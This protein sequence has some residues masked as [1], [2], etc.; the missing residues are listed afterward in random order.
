MSDNQ[1]AVVTD[2]KT[3]S[4][5]VVPSASA[6]DTQDADLME[7]P[8]V[9]IVLDVQ[10]KD[11]DVEKAG[12]VN[13]EAADDT[14]DADTDSSKAPSVINPFLDQI[15]DHSLE[16]G[17]NFF[18]RWI[19]TYLSPLLKLG[20]Q[21]VL[22]QQDV[23]APS[24]EDRA[25]RIY[26]LIQG[27]WASECSKAHKQMQELKIKK[28]EAAKQKKPTK[29]KTATTTAVVSGAADSNTTSSKTKTKTDSLGNANTGE[30]DDCIVVPGLGWALLSSFGTWRFIWAVLLYMLSALL[31]FVPVLLLNDLVRYFEQG[32]ND[33]SVL[34]LKNPWIEVVLLGILPFVVSLLQ[35]QNQVIMT[36][37]AIFVKTGCST[38]L[39]KKSLTISATG[40]A[41]TS[42]GQVVNMMSNDTNQLQ[43]FLQFSG[44]FLVAPLQIILALVLI[45]QQ[46]GNAMW[47]GVAYMVSLIPANIFIFSVVGKM[48]FK[49]LK[50][51]DARVKMMNEVLMGIRI[52][53]FY[54]WEQPFGKEVDKLR[55]KELQALTKLTYVS[56]IGF[57]VILMS[58]PIIQPIL[59]FL[60]YINIQDNPLTAS[61]AFTTVALFNIMRFPFAFLPMGF[62]QYIQATIS[63]KRLAAYLDLPEL[64]EDT[65][66]ARAPPGVS[67]DSPQAQVGSVTIH[68]GTFGWTNPNES[69]EPLTGGGPPKIGP[70]MS[71]R[72]SKSS[73]KG[74]GSVTGASVTASR[75][76]SKNSLASTGEAGATGTNNKLDIEIDAADLSVKESDPEILKNISLEL[77]AGTLIAVVGE[78]G[79]GK[80]S[81]LSAILG[82][83]E[84]FH[85]TKVYIP[86]GQDYHSNDNDED[87][88]SAFTAFCTQTPWVVN[89]TLKGNI[90]FGRPLDSARYDQVVHACALTDDLAILP[91]GDM[92]EI[93]EHGIN[94]SGGQ[95]ARVCLARA[96]YSRDTKLLLLDDPLSAV[97]SHVGQHLFKEA[98]SN[99]APVSQGTTRVLVTHHV[100]FLPQCDF[101]VVLKGGRIE[102]QGTYDE[103][104]AKGVDFAGAID[105][106]EVE[107]ESKEDDANEEEPH[108]ELVVKAN[109]SEE[110]EGSFVDVTSSKSKDQH[111]VTLKG[112]ASERSVGSK[113]DGGT[114]TATTTTDKAKS[115]T[116]SA[117]SDKKNGETLI[118]EEEREEGAVGSA[119]YMKYA[120]AGGMAYAV[121]IMFTQACARGF[122]VGGTFWLAY[123]STQSARD[124]ANGTPHNVQQTT[125]FMG[126]YALFGVLSIV[127]L[128]SRAILMAVHRLRASRLLHKELASSIL[129]APVAFFDVT[130]TGRILNRF[131]YDTDKVDLELSNSLSQ[132][133]N[134]S[135]SVLGA[136][137]AITASTKGTFLIPL[138]P[139]SYVYYIIQA[140]F[141]RTSTELQRVNSMTG[142]PIFADFSQTLSGTPTVRAFGMQDRF[143]RKCKSSFDSNNASY[144][145]VQVAN[146]WLGLR[147]DILGGLIGAFIAAL[148]VATAPYGFIPA[149][150]LG[151]ALTFSIEITGYLKYGVRMIA[152]VEADLT[153]VERILYYANHIT[154]EAPALVPA[155]DP[156]QGTWPTKGAIDVQHAS[157]RY[158]DGPLVL[159]DLSFQIQGGEKIGVVGR[160]GSGKSSFMIALFRIAELESNKSSI[161]GG[162]T[163]NSP[164]GC[165]KI[166]GV[167]CG[168]IGTNT[169][170]SNLSIIPQDPVLFSN[171][172]RYNLDPFQ[173]KT[174]DEIWDAL[175]KVQL[176]DSI[177]LLQK[178]L[179][180]L[181]TEGGDNFSQ[182]QRQ[183]LCIARS[184]LRKPKILVMDEATASIDNTTDAAI[185]DM[186]RSNFKDATVL[187]IA[188]RL[189]TIMDSD[190]VLVLKDGQ[191]AEFDS[192]HNLLQDPQ[193]QFYSMVQEHRSK[194]NETDLVITDIAEDG[195]DKDGK[196]DN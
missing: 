36:H 62:L 3:T 63:V 114:M 55:E 98:I 11:V 113:T 33:S 123:W 26:K 37:C 112:R 173:T 169:L 139:L 142:S 13:E 84:A 109:G 15:Q 71:R 134:T 1:Q 51:S 191:V 104:V 147:L 118:K 167:N 34:M 78:V 172:I 183:L 16:D 44:N 133:L 162:T 129:R 46:V 108:T 40:R 89:D 35:T 22:T 177:A 185:Q 21:K 165:I 2:T 161:D 17:A 175:Q 171:T 152:T 66:I 91:A 14:D 86:K 41:R 130:P 20:S 92:T 102:H 158:R 43:R 181:V 60:T 146:L 101:V 193:S 150:W 61:K 68:N 105:V 168:E 120:K 47:V 178:G 48:R 23:G 52:I 87:R 56:Q 136:L 117:S 83:M 28:K 190:R 106:K 186:I 103:L 127:G 160:T 57:S 25:D 100:H 85:G 50:F 176:G 194:K 12:G 135:F 115:T 45:Y 6:V 32:G 82:E 131:A 95:K 192:P 128:V 30:D 31:Q 137:G 53:K 125:Y 166:D 141:R 79:S 155:K 24:D 179:D 74:G 77:Q 54:A 195:E 110:E 124:F 27:Q 187:T 157:L 80:S 189:N 140:W 65:V 119:A 39:Y 156:P 67:K 70:S 73:N 75:R 154:H 174:D 121:S 126:I 93:G 170:R 163:S 138:L 107:K 90:V 69:T 58:A 18:Q 81:L 122:E 164:T 97:D 10:D 99:G 188:H 196:K 132:A 9:D 49:V 94:L 184:L 96:M 38:L 59:V 145:L 182:G 64:A 19:L 159:K 72:G 143:F 116:K 180:E 76:S 111:E 153:S 88:D 29:T 144:F 5:S 7:Q 4:S 151:L 148:S 149:G 8:L 42:T